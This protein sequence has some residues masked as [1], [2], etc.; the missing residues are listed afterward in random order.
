METQLPLDLPHR[1]AMGRD[2]FLVADSNETAVALIDRWPDWPAPAQAIVGPEGSGK[3]HLGEVWRMVSGA[4]TVPAATL[5]VEAVPRIAQG[6]A[7]LIEDAPGPSLDETAMFHL[8]NHLRE[9]SGF[10]LVLT[11]DAPAS[12]RVRLPDLASRLRA[13]PVTALDQ[14]DERLLRAVLVKLFADRQIAVNENVIA[15]MVVRMERSLGAARTL[16][17]RI[18][19]LAMAKKVPVTRSLV[20]QVL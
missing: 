18:D 19:R 6:G 17:E 1:P 5:T 4:E 11:R 8:L 20:A 10:A 3:S 2:D 16:V 13:V 12:W 7:V 15:Y 9:T 14:P